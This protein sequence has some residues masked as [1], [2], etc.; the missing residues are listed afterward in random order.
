MHGQAHIIQDRCRLLIIGV[1]Q[2]FNGNEARDRRLQ[3]I[4][5]VIRSDALFFQRIEDATGYEET[6]RRKIHERG[7]DGIECADDDDQ[8]QHPCKIYRI[9]K[10]HNKFQN[11][12]ECATAHACRGKACQNRQTRM[13]AE[14]EE[15]EVLD[16]KC[17][18]Q[19]PDRFAG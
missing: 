18:G 1:S 4:L 15:R 3:V 16:E 10:I 2:M 17:T 11:R 8:R 13:A 12:N 19:C 5:A 14:F 6:E 7:H 9:R